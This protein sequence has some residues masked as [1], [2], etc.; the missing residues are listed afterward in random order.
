MLDVILITSTLVIWSAFV[1]VALTDKLYSNKAACSEG[2]QTGRH[3]KVV[4]GTGG[5]GD[6]ILCL[7][8][9]MEC[10]DDSGRIFGGK[11]DYPVNYDT[12]LR[13]DFLPHEEKE[14]IHAE[15]EE[16]RMLQGGLNDRLKQEDPRFEE[17]FKSGKSS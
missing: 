3:G 12:M 6:G 17:W 13:L 9:G 8:C 1:Y 2:N 4:Y 15:M 7:R 16:A 5:T 14:S 10:Y 11:F